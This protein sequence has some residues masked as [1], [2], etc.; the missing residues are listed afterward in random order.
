VMMLTAPNWPSLS[1]NHAPLNFRRF[2]SF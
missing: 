2:F 1:R